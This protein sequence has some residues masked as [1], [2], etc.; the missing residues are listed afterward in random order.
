MSATPPEAPSTARR[1]ALPSPFRL[2]TGGAL[3]GAAVAVETYGTLAPAR[4]NAILL[5]TGLSAS[6]HAAAHPGDPSP[7]WWDAMIGPGC[8][9]DTDRYYVVSVNSLG[10]CFGST[11][12]ASIHPQ[13]GQPYAGD[14]PEMRVEDIARA[15]QAA[16]EALGIETLYAVIGC[17]LGGMTVLAHAALFPGRA[18]GL[19]SISGAMTANAAA[20]ATRSLQREIVGSL[21]Q[22]GAAPAQ[23]QQAMRWARKIGILSYVG[24][25]LLEQR[26]GRDQA[27]PYAGRGSGT[28]FEVESWLEHLAQ[29]F[30][31]TF[32]PWAYW[33]ISRAMDLF[34][35]GTFGVAAGP[36]GLRHR[37]ATDTGAAARTLQLQQALVVGVR[38]DL[39]FPV[40]QQ[41]AL[42][43]T[44]GAAGIDCGYVE[45]S[46]PYGHDAFLADAAL[47]TP[48]LSD[49]LG[50]LARPNLPRAL[51]PNV[52]SDYA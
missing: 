34:D 8:A 9:L 12:P 26:F 1:I 38:E 3:Y 6:A 36:D 29:K 44:L 37:G 22:S 47:F 20:I 30:V 45:L 24:T 21:L 48:I 51:Q 11:G 42:A 23:V 43:Q 17:S 52:R 25:E 35:F 14:F 32:D 19:V 28:D 5:F 15:S 49:F 18:R 10:S 31:R 50:G 16:V 2:T 7:G 33:T 4:D 41:R 13:T 46:S 40:G 39:L 27:E